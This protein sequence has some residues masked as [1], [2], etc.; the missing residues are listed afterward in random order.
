MFGFILEEIDF[1]P[2]RREAHATFRNPFAVLERAI[3]NAYNINLP[4]DYNV[5]T[6][7]NVSD[8]SPYINDEYQVDLGTNLLQQKEDVGGPSQKFLISQGCNQL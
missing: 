7:F 6:T 4:G 3:D 8:L 5:S 1:Q 2:R